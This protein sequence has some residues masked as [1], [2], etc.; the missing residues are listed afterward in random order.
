MLT[1]EQIENLTEEQE[2][3]FINHAIEYDRNTKCEKCGSGNL[4]ISY[5]MTDNSRHI[6]C[7]DC[8]NKTYEN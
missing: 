5:P 2:M 8:K 6:F 1:D 3:W 4:K 7:F